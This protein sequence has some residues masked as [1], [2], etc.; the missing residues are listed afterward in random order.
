MK[1]K[2]KAGI[3]RPYKLR[4]FVLRPHGAE[5]RAFVPV[6]GKT[7]PP[8][9]RA[10]APRVASSFIANK[11]NKF[12]NALT[13]LVVFTVQPPLIHLY[14]VARFQFHNSFSLSSFQRSKRQHLPLSLYT[15]YHIFQESQVKNYFVLSKYQNTPIVDMD[16]KAG[17]GKIR[18]IKKYSDHARNY[19]QCTCKQ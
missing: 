16:S 13:R 5:I 2:K 12:T 7:N 15:L 18:K 14:S 10:K 1:T 6:I 4:N 17:I 11:F 19:K 9:F 3:N 8:S